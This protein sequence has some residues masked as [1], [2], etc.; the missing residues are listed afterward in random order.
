[1]AKPISN[2]KRAAIVKHMQAGE[3]KGE[4]AK[5]LLVNKRTVG[6][7]WS[8]YQKQ[9]Y[10]EP[11]PLNCGRKTLVNKTTPEAIVAKIKHQPDIALLEF[12]DEF[13]LSLSKSALCRCQPVS[14]LIFTNLNTLY[15]VCVVLLYT[16]YCGLTS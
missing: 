7:V 10:Y 5:W 13:K 2:D 12:I 3:N 16:A 14:K 1:M 15:T 4:V 8:K 6:R 11:E 9:G